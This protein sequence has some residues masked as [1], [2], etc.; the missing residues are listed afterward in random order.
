MKT[1]LLTLAICLGS[2]IGVAQDLVSFKDENGKFGYKNKEGKVVIQSQYNSVQEFKSNDYAIA[3][4]YL[5]DK[6]GKTILSANDIAERNK[7]TG[8]IRLIAEA[9]NNELWITVTGEMNSNGKYAKIDKTGKVVSEW[10]NGSVSTIG[11]FNE[12]GY[13]YK[14][15]ERLLVCE[16]MLNLTNNN[17]DIYYQI[18]HI[19]GDIISEKYTYFEQACDGYVVSK[20][21]WNTYDEKTG[22]KLSKKY[23]NL[24]KNY[25]KISFFDFS[26]KCFKVDRNFKL[27]KDIPDNFKDSSGPNI[28]FGI[29]QDSTKI[30]S[31]RSSL[32]T[33]SSIRCSEILFQK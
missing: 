11:Y 26:G 24:A 33:G 27:I 32:G 17:F 18:M 22:T 8:H 4:G 23:S 16:Y 5:I 12:S 20:E 19:N 10:R 9:G 6:T 13:F 31:T 2:I 21:K 28:T 30:E 3:D 15:P 29:N 14:D 7:M 1:T 25:K